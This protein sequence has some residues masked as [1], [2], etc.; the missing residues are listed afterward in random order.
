MHVNTDGNDK[1]TLSVLLNF[2]KT[3][4]R[5]LKSAKLLAI[6]IALPSG[7]ITKSQIA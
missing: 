4:N 1:V 3:G 5:G 6:Y 2:D 7:S